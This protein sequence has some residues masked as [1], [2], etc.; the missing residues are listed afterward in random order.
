MTH[1]DS[2]GISPA[3]NIIFVSNGFDTSTLSFTADKLEN[4]HEHQD[5]L[6][7]VE[8]FHDF[9]NSIDELNI[10]PVKM[11]VSVAQFSDAF[12]DRNEFLAALR[13]ECRE[14]VYV[15]ALRYYTNA[16]MFL[17]S[18][19][20]ERFNAR[21]AIPK[22]ELL[23]F[24]DDLLPAMNRWIAENGL[25]GRAQFILKQGASGPMTTGNPN[26]RYFSV[27]F[28]DEVFSG[29]TKIKFTATRPEAHEPAPPLVL[30]DDA[31]F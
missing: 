23:T 2:S 20:A 21:L 19:D 8:H 14:D 25:K 28:R 1:L 7:G 5:P 11:S 4:F 16:L 18:E 15:Q 31:P 26:G 13:Q 3:M 12:W 6:S 24:G 30:E 9:W 10:K 22:G 17:S 27:V 29:L